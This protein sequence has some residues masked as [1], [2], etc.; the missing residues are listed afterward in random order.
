MN[1]ALKECVLDLV[2]PR[3]CEHC[4]GLVEDDSVWSYLCGECVRRLDWIHPPWCGICGHPFPGIGWGQRCDRCEE[5]DAVFEAG[6]CCFLHREVGATLVRALKYQGARY[7]R[8]D[9]QC[10]V[11]RV[12]D[13]VDFVRGAILV[14]V[15]LHPARERERGFNQSAELARAWSEVLPV[16][17][18]EN[19]LER[20]AWTHSQ[21]RLSRAERQQN[22]RGAFALRGQAGIRADLTYIVV[23]DVFTTGSTLNEC[24][25]IL[26][27]AGVKS[28]RV[29]TLAHG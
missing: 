13:L 27:R 23:D 11:A 5:L 14:P 4:G 15:P 25:R 21:T 10:T 8:R 26:R 3:S 7:L 16:A 29:L 20:I 1:R 9:L 2:F 18:A 24:C 17:G 12:P 19:V 6:R 28:L 22:I